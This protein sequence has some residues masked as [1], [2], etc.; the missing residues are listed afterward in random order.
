MGCDPALVLLPKL[1]ASRET[2]LELEAAVAKQE[3]RPEEHRMVLHGLHARHVQH[4]GR[5]GVRRPVGLESVQL[6]AVPDEHELLA[7]SDTLLERLVDVGRALEE[8]PF[9]QRRHD[10][11]H[12]DEEPAFQPGHVVVVVVAVRLVDD[13]RCAGHEPG[14]ACDDPHQAAVR[15]NDVVSLAPEQLRGL[16]DGSGDG[17]R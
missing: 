4:D 16:H 12:H 6:D 11:F 14:K 1:P 5:V 9:G 8:V 2:D 17:D 15:V 13:V 7:R 3:R 10:T